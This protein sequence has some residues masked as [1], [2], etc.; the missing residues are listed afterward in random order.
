MWLSAK[1]KH[2]HH[3][4]LCKWLLHNCNPGE[5]CYILVVLMVG[6]HH[7]IPE[8]KYRKPHTSIGSVIYKAIGR[9]NKRHGII[10]AT[11]EVYKAT[12]RLGDGSRLILRQRVPGSGRAIRAVRNTRVFQM[13]TRVVADAM[14]H[15][16]IMP[17]PV[18]KAGVSISGS[19]R[20]TVPSHCS[21]Q[22]WA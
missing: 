21:R 13:E 4:V 3:Q 17:I 14:I 19:S 18:P 7:H 15:Q 6:I 20:C 1:E 11:R 9:N 16:Q 12:C 22:G 10:A 8:A 2:K 5:E